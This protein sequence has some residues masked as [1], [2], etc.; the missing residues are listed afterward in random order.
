MLK[1]HTDHSPEVIW[2]QSKGNIVHYS[3]WGMMNAALMENKTRKHLYVGADDK[4]SK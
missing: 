4:N 1:A 2:M 3:V